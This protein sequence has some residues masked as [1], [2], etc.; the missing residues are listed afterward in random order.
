MNNPILKFSESLS[1]NQAPKLLPTSDKLRGEI[2][3]ILKKEKGRAKLVNLQSTL[4]D[5]LKKYDVTGFA[6]YSELRDMIAGGIL[7][8]DNDELNNKSIISSNVYKKVVK[9]ENSQLKK[10]LLISF[11]TLEQEIESRTRLIPMISLHCEYDYSNDR[12]NF[13]NNDITLYLISDK[14]SETSQFVKEWGL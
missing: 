14:S 5:I 2:V 1:G 4:P 6:V 3:E 8:I 10:E 9:K 13:T 11:N 7:E 12:D